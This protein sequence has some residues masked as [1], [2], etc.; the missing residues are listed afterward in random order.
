MY[1]PYVFG[2]QSEL[3]AIRS[4]CEI[5]N[6]TGLV[7]PLIEPVNANPD[8]LIRCLDKAG[9][10]SLRLVVI[11]NPH[12]GEFSIGG[13]TAWA[14]AVDPVMS[15]Y[16]TLMPA[17]SCGPATDLNKINQ[18]RKRY[19]GSQIALVYTSPDLSDAE[20]SE[21]AKHSDVSFHIVIH[22]KMSAAH[23]AL[24]PKKKLVDIRDYFNK[25]ARNAD[26]GGRELFT[27]SHKTFKSNGAGFGD[28]TI[29][30]AVFDPGGG[31]PGAVAIH[32]I[33]K[34]SKNGDIWIDHFVSDDVDRDIGDAAG[35]YLQAAKKL[36]A[37]L[38]ARK[39]EFGTNAALAAHIADVQASH[40]PGLPKSKERQ[41]HHH[42]A[43]VHD[44]LTGK[45]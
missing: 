44:I 24:L 33:Y 7:V 26:Y 40:F 12:Q 20:F 37:S 21:L 23:K 5:C 8:D 38:K 6:Q 25:K 42:I 15:K 36:V 11:M 32:A 35:K 39:A 3:L 22:G 45:L 13:I 10:A 19:A 28:Y 16:A 4:L 30:G 41:I 14:K 43:L 18:F 17:L 31:K 2:R 34:N 27:D 1:F 9:K 29:V